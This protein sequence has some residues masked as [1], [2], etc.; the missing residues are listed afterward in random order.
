M[1]TK[2][3]IELIGYFGSLLVVVSMLMTSVMKLRIINTI[4]STIFTCYALVIHSYPTA[5]MNMA[6]IVINIVNMRK[7]A[8]G[9]DNYD[10]IEVSAEDVYLKNFIENLIF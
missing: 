3:I 6:L 8:A 4:G 9:A 7:L 5:V 1:D 10:V 2:M